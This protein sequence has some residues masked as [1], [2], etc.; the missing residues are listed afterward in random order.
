MDLE[1]RRTPAGEPNSPW[2]ELPPCVLRTLV[3]V[4]E[5]SR[6][7]IKIVVLSDN[8]SVAMDP[9][10]PSSVMTSNVT[11]PNFPTR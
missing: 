8:I 5:R 2:H 9:E 7:R 11:K 4:P 3:M 1:K 6:P 10:L